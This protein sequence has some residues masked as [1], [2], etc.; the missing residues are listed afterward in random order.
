[1]NEEADGLGDRDATGLQ[2][3]RGSSQ[4]HEH[5]SAQMLPTEHPAITINPTH[6]VNPAQVTCP[7]S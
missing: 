2:R 3:R 5:T 6:N 1:M 7:N 4:E